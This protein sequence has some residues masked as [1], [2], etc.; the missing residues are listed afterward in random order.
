MADE[1]DRPSPGE[2]LQIA[3]EVRDGNVDPAD[4]MRLLAHFC[5][6]LDS[7][8]KIPPELLRHLHDAFSVYLN[9]GKTLEAA[10]DLIRR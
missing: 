4:A 9:D 10:L 1:V 8:S 6:C 5:N 2:I 7:N 3:W